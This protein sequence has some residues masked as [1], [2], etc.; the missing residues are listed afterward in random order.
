MDAAAAAAAVVA[1]VV[2]VD[3]SHH[4]CSHSLVGKHDK[5]MMIMI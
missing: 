2:Y 5:V 3:V 4:R 1:H